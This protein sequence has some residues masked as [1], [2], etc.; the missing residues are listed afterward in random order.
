VEAWRATLRGM[1]FAISTE[2]AGVNIGLMVGVTREVCWHQA[3]EKTSV[4][5]GNCRIT[6]L[7]AEGRTMLQM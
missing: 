7:D 3:A 5:S 6:V 2:I 1:D 4:T